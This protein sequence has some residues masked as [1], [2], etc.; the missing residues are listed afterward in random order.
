M[1]EELCNENIISKDDDGLGEGRVIIVEGR[2]DD[3]F[4][5][6]GVGEDID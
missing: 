5:E 1:R 6:D 3:L 2:R 4:V